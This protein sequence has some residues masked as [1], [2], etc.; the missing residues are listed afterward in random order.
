MHVY[1]ILIPRLNSFHTVWVS[2][3]TGVIN[4]NSPLPMTFQDNEHNPF[5]SLKKNLSTYLFHNYNLHVWPSLQW[6]RLIKEKVG[7][8]VGVGLSAMNM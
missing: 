3:D 5:K 1:Q 6:H 8:A 2:G 7:T 4:L